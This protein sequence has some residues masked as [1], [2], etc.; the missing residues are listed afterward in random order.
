MNVA[1][2]RTESKVIGATSRELRARR[3]KAVNCGSCPIAVIFHVLPRFLRTEGVIVL[4]SGICRL[5][6]SRVVYYIYMQSK[7]T[8][9]HGV[10]TFEAHW[11]QTSNFNGARP[12]DAAVDSNL[13]LGF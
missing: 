13:I 1:R 7:M 3:L 2:H 6:T 4:E 9:L 8:E 5:R 10:S 12:V 11:I